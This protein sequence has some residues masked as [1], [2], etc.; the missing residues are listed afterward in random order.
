MIQW[1]EL[2]QIASSI[3]FSEE[4]GALIWKFESSGVFTIKSMYVVVNF[5][6]VLPVHVHHVWD[7]KIPPKIHFFL[8]L[9]AHRKNLTRDN[10]VKR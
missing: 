6:G 9:L 7:I 1:Y 3:Q 2:V 10:L 4:S 5:K 8:G